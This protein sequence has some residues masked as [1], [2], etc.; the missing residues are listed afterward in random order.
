MWSFEASRCIDCATR[1]RN[2]NVVRRV[3][4]AGKG[5]SYLELNVATR[6]AV[7]VRQCTDCLLQ[8]LHLRQQPAD[9]RRYSN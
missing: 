2:T 5:G 9:G 7:A 1:L 8:R 3:Q 4:P 6:R